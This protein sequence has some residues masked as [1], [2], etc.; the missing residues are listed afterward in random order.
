VRGTIARGQTLVWL[1]GI[2]GDIFEAQV[3]RLA[4]DHDGP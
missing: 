3:A 4:V 1:G 2:W